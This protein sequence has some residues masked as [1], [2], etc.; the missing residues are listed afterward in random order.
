MPVLTEHQLSKPP[1]PFT[2]LIFCSQLYIFTFRFV[3]AVLVNYEGF[4]SKISK[5]FQEKNA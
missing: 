5:T 3:K 1:H 2:Q 4:Y